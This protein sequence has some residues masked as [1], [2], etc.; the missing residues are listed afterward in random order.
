MIDYI[1]RN[2]KD[3]DHDL[4]SW[5]PE[6]AGFCPEGVTPIDEADRHDLYLAW[7]EAKRQEKEAAQRRRQIEDIILGAMGYQPGEE[8]SKTI[9]DF[10]DVVKVTSR[11]N[12]KVDA[13]AVQEIAAE[14]GLTQHLPD[15]F[16]WKPEINMAAWKAADE[17][18]TKPLEAAITTKPSRPSFSIEL[19]QNEEG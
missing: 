13:D 12:R 1:T 7:A 18:I 9:N 11:L 17:S 2:Q 8:G 5:T 3:P 14:H 6:E 10:G 19:N 15:L 4:D 16:R